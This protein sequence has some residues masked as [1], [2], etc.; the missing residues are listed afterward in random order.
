MKHLF[1][2]CLAKTQHH[3]ITIASLLK[4]D[5]HCAQILFQL[6]P[7]LKGKGEPGGEECN[8]QLSLFI[9]SDTSIRFKWN[10]T[11]SFPQA[12]FTRENCFED[13]CLLRE[14]KQS[15]WI[16]REYRHSFTHRLL[17]FFTSQFTFPQDPKCMTVPSTYH[18]E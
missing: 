18:Y 17:P 2:N 10:H 12:K 13:V 7:F 16:H 3:L 14:A 1:L 5:T 4:Q 15:S 6:E 11:V 9:S 8:S